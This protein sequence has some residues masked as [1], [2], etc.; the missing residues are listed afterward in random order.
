MVLIGLFAIFI[1]T[2]YTVNLK[3]QQVFGYL[4][5]VS[6]AVALFTFG[7][8]WMILLMLSGAG[9]Y[10]AGWI[11]DFIPSKFYRLIPRKNTDLTATFSATN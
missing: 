2:I 11:W 7:L 10:V 9:I 1:Y 8:P 3:M 4:F 5:L 6:A